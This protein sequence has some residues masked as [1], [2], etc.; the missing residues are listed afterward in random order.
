MGLFKIAAQLLSLRKL[1]EYVIASR[2]RGVAGK[3]NGVHPDILE[4]RA[5]SIEHRGIVLANQSSCYNRHCEQS[6][7]LNKWWG[8]RQGWR[9]AS[10]P[11]DVSES[12]SCHEVTEGAAMQSIAVEEVDCVAIGDREGIFH[13]KL[14]SHLKMSFQKRPI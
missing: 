10:E 11:Q 12:L 2:S 4:F 7:L 3:Q 8:C 6:M 14:F 13:P 5:K 9:R 1:Q